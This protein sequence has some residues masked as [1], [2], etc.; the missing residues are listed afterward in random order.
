M[1]LPKKIN[2]VPV[3]VSLY[4]DFPSCPFRALVAC[5]T[6][7]PVGNTT[8]FDFQQTVISLPG[9]ASL[10]PSVLMTLAFLSRPEPSGYHVEVHHH[11]QVRQQE[12]LSAGKVQGL[13][14]G[15]G[16]FLPAPSNAAALTSRRGLG[17]GPA[18]EPLHF[19][20]VSL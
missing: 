18:R 12:F 13:L 20:Y 6:Q 1:S 4:S 5:L 10:L 16:V 17:V 7:S 11:G 3:I 14:Q 19:N 9:P 15:I 2:T 8:A